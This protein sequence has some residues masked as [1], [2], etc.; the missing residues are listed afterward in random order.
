MHKK[1][2]IIQ[3]HRDIHYTWLRLQY[4]ILVHIQSIA[5]SASIQHA[6]RQRSKHIFHAFLQSK[7][8][9]LDDGVAPNSSTRPYSRR[10][11]CTGVTTGPA[12]MCKHGTKHHVH[13]TRSEN[14]KD[15]P[16][17]VMPSNSQYR[18]CKPQDLS[19][20]YWPIYNSM[21][22]A[23]NRNLTVCD[24]EPSIRIHS[25]SRTSNTWLFEGGAWCN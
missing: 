18:P 20:F 5:P 14:K 3:H 19:N 4:D 23:F 10:Y 24:L 25:M 11:R 22:T 17:S 7:R 6:P 2:N 1:N 8:G 13:H 15:Q 9:T 21:A 16:S 12:D